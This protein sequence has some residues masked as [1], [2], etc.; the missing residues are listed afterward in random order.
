V[1][2]LEG[3]TFVLLA[4]PVDG[5]EA[6]PR[7]ADT[8]LTGLA[9]SGGAGILGGAAVVLDLVGQEAGALGQAGRGVGDAESAADGNVVVR[10][11][12]W[13]SWDAHLR[14][15]LAGAAYLA[16]EAATR[17]ALEIEARAVGDEA[18]LHPASVEGQ[19]VE[20]PALLQLSG[21]RALAESVAA[22][23]LEAGDLGPGADRYQLP[24]HLAQ[25]ATCRRYQ[26]PIGELLIDLDSAL[27]IARGKQIRAVASVPLIAVASEYIGNMY[28]NLGSSGSPGAPR[29]AGCRL[30]PGGRGC[31][32]RAC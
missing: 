15:A 27:L 7:P 14:A 20:V 2:A 26:D 9:G 3:H 25:G 11:V 32:C 19:A 22:L 21:G 4:R 18:A 12:A 1:V 10:A 16:F 6:D 23:V 8:A 28:R 5:R 30:G 31:S 13:E 24:R 29:A 17:I